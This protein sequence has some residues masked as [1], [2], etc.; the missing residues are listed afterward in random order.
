MPKKSSDKDIIRQ[1]LLTINKVWSKG[2]PDDLNEYFHED[3]VILSPELQ[4]MGEDKGAFEQSYKDFMAQAMVH[5][6]REMDHII[7]V[8]EN[9]VVATY[10]FDICFE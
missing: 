2:N 3:L 8:W 9:T 4:R 1:I 5:D 7:D 6:Y 10:A